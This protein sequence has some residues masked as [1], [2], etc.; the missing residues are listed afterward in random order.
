MNGNDRAIVGLVMGAHAMVHTYELSIP[1]LVSVWLVEFDTISVLSATFPVNAATL[2]VV[3]SVGYALFGL[4]ALLAGVLADTYGSRPLIALCLF[5][6]GGSFLLL[7]LAPGVVVIA[8]ALVCWGAAASVYHPSGLALIS[9][10]VHERGSAFAYHGMAGNLGIALGPLA[11]TIALLAFGWRTVAG[12]L[13]IPALIAGL[14]ALR[15]DID[16][17][18]AVGATEDG[19]ENA[20]ADGGERERSERE[21]RRSAERSD[22]GERSEAS[23]SSSAERSESDSGER[24]RTGGVRSFG[25]FVASSKAL[26]A[27]VFVLVFGVAMLSGLYYR[28]VLTFLPEI[29]SSFPEFEPVA[30]AGT[31]LQP[32]RYFYAGL[33]MVGVLGQYVGG[34]L[35]DHIRPAAGIAG[36]YGVLAVLAVLFLPVARAGIVPLL[37]VGAAL[38][39]FLFFVQ[40]L[41]QAAIAE[42][43]PPE[44]RGISYGYTYLGVFGVGALG[45]TIAGAILTALSPAALFAVLAGF[46][47]LAALLG[48]AVLVRTEGSLT[49]A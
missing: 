45:G 39:F 22:S 41:Y 15:A 8:L 19:V 9:K 17:T 34:R 6:M 49:T 31:E 30:V 3:V 13:A 42:F 14:F 1:I 33:L 21:S 44:A 37:I 7:G 2:G 46:G 48:V 5:G 32:E 36:G 10:G 35:T 40:P 27:G 28:G 4:G 12:L 25:E 23:R 47:A 26:F 24:E 18:A 11:T 29:L 43:S 20:A 38:G 16:E